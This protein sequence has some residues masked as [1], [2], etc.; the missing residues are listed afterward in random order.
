MS[1][2]YKFNPLGINRSINYLESTGTQYINLNLSPNDISEIEV[3]ASKQGG[4]SGNFGCRSGSGYLEFRC[5]F[6]AVNIDI[7]YINHLERTGD[8]DTSAI[9]TYYMSTNGLLKVNGNTLVNYDQAITQSLSIYLFA[10][11]NNG[12]AYLT[13]VSNRIYGVKCTKNDN[14]IMQLIP[15]I[16]NNNTPCFY[17]KINNAYLYNAGTGDFV[18]G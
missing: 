9:N 10:F 3:I 16:D 12:T 17:D 18:Y 14:V 15:I 7:A 6:G 11:N 13:G 4:T 2:P 8:Y 5:T 1:I